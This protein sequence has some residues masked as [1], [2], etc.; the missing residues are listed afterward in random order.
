MRALLARPAMAWGLFTFSWRLASALAC[1]L[2]CFFF[3]E[4]VGPVLAFFFLPPMVCY[5]RA[6]TAVLP[7]LDALPDT[8]FLS[9]SML[10]TSQ[11]CAASLTL[12]QLNSTFETTNATNNSAS[13]A[14]V[15]LAVV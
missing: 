15:C 8:H 5:D 9:R 14:C 6:I 7:V 1:A 12:V 2:A 4:A 3:C 10:S 13:M 11:F